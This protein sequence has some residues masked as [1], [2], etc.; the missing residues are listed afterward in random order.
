MSKFIEPSIEEI[1]LEKLYQDMGLSDA[2]YN[3]VCEI[4]GREPNF[5]EV[6][7]FSVMWSEH[8]SY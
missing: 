8:C 4:L 1:K 7:I 3:K 6:G 5:T 2:E